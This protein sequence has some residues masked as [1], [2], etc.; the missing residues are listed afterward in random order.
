MPYDEN[1]D[2]VNSSVGS[3]A[4]RHGRLRRVRSRAGG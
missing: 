2:G 4:R 1:F 3:A